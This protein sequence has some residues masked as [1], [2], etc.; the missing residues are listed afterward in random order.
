MS[1]FNSV[2]CYNS[3]KNYVY[4]VVTS[5]Q[6]L[7]YLSSSPPDISI[8]GDP[9]DAA[10]GDCQHRLGDVV[11]AQVRLVNCSQSALSSLH[12][13]AAVY[14]DQQNGALTYRL[15]NKVAVSGALGCSVEVVLPG[16][17][18]RHELGLVFFA[19]GKYTLQLVCATE[20]AESWTCLQPLNVV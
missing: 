5:P 13:R 16:E 9:V 19:A 1:V 6:S 17:A 10:A 18:M 2:Q 8:N 3:P 20:G 11:R 14:Q 4:N 15:E 7:T 12:L